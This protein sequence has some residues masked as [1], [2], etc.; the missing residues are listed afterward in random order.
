MQIPEMFSERAAG[1]WREKNIFPGMG[2][3]ESCTLHKCNLTGALG[4]SQN[5]TRE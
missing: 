3:G 1:A 2:R 5:F 4:D